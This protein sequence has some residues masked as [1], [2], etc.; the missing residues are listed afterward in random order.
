M[1][2]SE[3]STE[4][5]M[6]NTEVAV[7]S[8]ASNGTEMSSYRV[9]PMVPAVDEKADLCYNRKES[10]ERDL[11]QELERGQEGRGQGQGQGQGRGKHTLAFD[12]SYEVVK[13]R[14]LHNAVGTLSSGECLAIMGPSGG[15]Q[16]VLCDVVA[17][18]DALAD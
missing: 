3:R 14:I 15:K 5:D 13:K 1:V 16:A 4:I 11:E 12:V 7:A 8:G 18:F 17:V 2:R 6:T 10:Q 9:V